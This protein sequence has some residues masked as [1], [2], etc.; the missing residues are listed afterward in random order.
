MEDKHMYAPSQAIV[1][2]AHFG[3]TLEVQADHLVK[4]MYDPDYFIGYLA[5]Q[6]AIEADDHSGEFWDL[7]CLEI[8]GFLMEN[9]LY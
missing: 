1:I 3:I 7:K 2:A 5:S 6:I 8:E 4:G 9:D